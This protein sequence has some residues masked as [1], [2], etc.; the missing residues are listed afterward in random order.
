LYSN[1]PNPFNP[2]TTIR[3]SLAQAMK[4]SLRIYNSRGQLVNTL[5]DAALPAGQHSLV[6]NGKDCFG[7]DVASGV[8]FYRLSAGSRV[9]HRKMLLLK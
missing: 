5:L 2:S 4:A 6:W 3:F 7:R 8:Y 9:M 1:Y